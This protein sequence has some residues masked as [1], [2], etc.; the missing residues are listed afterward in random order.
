MLKFGYRTELGRLNSLTDSAPVDKVNFLRCY[1]KAR[2]LAFTRETI[3]NGFKVTGVWPISR[4]TA[5]SH[6]EIQNPI[7]RELTVSPDLESIA[8]LIG[9]F[10]PTNARQIMDLARDSDPRNRL[11][12]RKVAKAFGNKALELIEAKKSIEALEETL[13]RLQRGRK[14]KKIPNPNKRFMMIGETLGNGQAI[15]TISGTEGPLVV[16]SESEEVSDQDSIESIIEEPPEPYQTRSGR[17]VKP[18]KQY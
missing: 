17:V 9:P 15:A 18:K 5:L 12:F 2:E 3:K 4:E 14:R 6:P 7:P 16:A 11:L 10:T 8:A 1:I 13:Q